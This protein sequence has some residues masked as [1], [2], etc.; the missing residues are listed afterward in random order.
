MYRERSAFILWQ[1]TKRVIIKIY[2]TVVCALGAAALIGSIGA[3]ILK[4]TPESIEKLLDFIIF[5]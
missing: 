1:N 5:A 4:I 2:R 3:V